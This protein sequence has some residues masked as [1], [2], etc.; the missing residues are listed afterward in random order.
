MKSVLAVIPNDPLWAYIQKGELKTRYF[1]P[2]DVFEKVH[3]FTPSDDDADPKELGDIAG[4]AEVFVHPLGKLTVSRLLW[5]WPWVLRAA[6]RITRASPCA[7]RAYNPTYGGLAAVTAAHRLNIPSVISLHGNYDYDERYLLF[8]HRRFLS[9][10][11]YVYTGLFIESSTLRRASRV[12]AAYRFPAEY[13]RKC[14][15]EEERLE[16]IYN[17][18]DMSLFTPRTPHANDHR[19]KVVCVGRLHVL[20]GQYTLVRAMEGLDADLILVGDG[21]EYARLKKLVH[22]LKMDSRVTFYRSVPN[23]QLSSIY[24]QAD[25]F[26]LPMEYGGVSIPMFEAAASYL[27]LVLPRR[28]AVAS[29]EL[30]HDSALFVENS[31]K[32]FAEGIRRLLGDP[33]LRQQLGERGRKAVLAVDAPAMEA[34]EADMYRR[35]LDQVSLSNS[36]KIAPG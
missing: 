20:K 18:V 15:V 6:E 36:C 13:A 35:V 7:I 17:R 16:I 12:V 5:P 34:R 33:Q 25:V 3:F 27:P 29:P 31:P 24:K 22:H 8:K 21:E 2:N 10:L 14:G 26:A 30:V 23:K 9:C 11:K 19:L 1:N 4:K 32:G 28:T